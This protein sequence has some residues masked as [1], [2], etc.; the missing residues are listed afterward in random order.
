MGYGEDI[1]FKIKERGRIESGFIHT[2]Q[3]LVFGPPPKQT[4][5]QTGGKPAFDRSE[6]R[7]KGYLA[8]WGWSEPNNIR[9]PGR[10]SPGEAGLRNDDGFAIPLS[11]VSET[12]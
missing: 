11:R 1:A 10:I 2:R 7:Q 5:V 6:R 12:V 9:S 8:R 4:S 3:V